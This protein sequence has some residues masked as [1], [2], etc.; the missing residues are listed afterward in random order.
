VRERRRK[1]RPAATITV[2]ILHR[3]VPAVR[4]PQGLRA[5]SKGRPIE[6][7]SVQRYLEGKFGDA[8]EDARDAM[9]QLARALSPDRLAREAYSLYEKFR[10]RIPAG[11]KGWGVPGKLSLDAIRSLAAKKP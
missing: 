9:M 11:Q 3:A 6:P 7:A 2:D 1:L 4:T 5:L 8:L 10:P